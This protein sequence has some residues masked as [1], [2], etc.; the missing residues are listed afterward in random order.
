MISRISTKV[1]KITIYEKNK[2]HW[3]VGYKIADMISNEELHPVVTALFITS[4]KLNVFLLFIT[5][6]NAVPLQNGSRES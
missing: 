6:S 2:K 1:L 4:R 5:Q 3:S